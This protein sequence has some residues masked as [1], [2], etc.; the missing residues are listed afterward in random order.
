MRGF[1]TVREVASYSLHTTTATE[2]P[3][4]RCVLHEPR[5]EIHGNHNKYSFVP[6]ESRKKKNNKGQVRPTENKQ[7]DDNLRP[8]HGIIT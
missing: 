1:Y 2:V 8:N 4:Y 5:K 6:H 7:Q 3:E